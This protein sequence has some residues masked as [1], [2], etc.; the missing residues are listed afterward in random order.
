MQ[1][2]ERAVLTPEVLGNCLT[3]TEGDFIGVEVEHAQRVVFEQVF[4]HNVDAIVAHFVL[5]QTQFLEANVILEH[6]TKVN[7][8]ALANGAEDGVVDIQL[9]QSEVR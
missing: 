7:G 5:L 1:R 9:V 3:T 8:D 4:H 2:L 6:L